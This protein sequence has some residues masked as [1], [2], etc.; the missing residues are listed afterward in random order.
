LSEV[1]GEWVGNPEIKKGTHY[2]DQMAA[3]LNRQILMA[4]DGFGGHYSPFGIP[5]SNILL[6]PRADIS[7]SAASI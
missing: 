6:N 5:T 2:K 3:S 1:A 4:R 7:T